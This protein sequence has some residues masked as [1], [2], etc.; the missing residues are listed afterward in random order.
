MSPTKELGCNVN[1]NSSSFLGFHLKKMRIKRF[2]FRNFSG[3]SF[4]LGDY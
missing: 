4:Y 2:I 3:N 1:I